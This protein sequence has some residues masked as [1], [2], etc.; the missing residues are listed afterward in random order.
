MSE[1]ISPSIQKYIKKR[2]SFERIQCVDHSVPFL[3]LYGGGRHTDPKSTSPFPV[4]PLFSIWRKY[5][6]LDSKYQ[7]SWVE[8]KKQTLAFFF[9][10]HHAQTKI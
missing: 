8:Q 5:P 3:L 6:L 7:F 2:K 1:W 10:M 4:F 9:G